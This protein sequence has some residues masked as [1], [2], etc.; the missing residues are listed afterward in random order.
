[1]RVRGGIPRHHLEPHEQLLLRLSGT[2]LPTRP[3]CGALPRHRSLLQ[4]VLQRLHH[5]LLIT[6]RYVLVLVADVC[7]PLH[8]SRIDTG[9]GVGTAVDIFIAAY[10][11][12]AYTKRLRA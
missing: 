5:R 2:F 1:M 6:K 8:V 3:P 9:R 7:F 11:T 4:R 10:F 12:N